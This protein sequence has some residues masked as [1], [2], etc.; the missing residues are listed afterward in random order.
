MPEISFT[1]ILDMPRAFQLKLREYRNNPEIQEYFF[2]HNI[3]LE[4]HEKWLDSL[5][6][7]ENKKTFIFMCDGEPAGCLNISLEDN[8]AGLGIY[9]F[10]LV[11]YVGTGISV[12]AMAY[13]I[14]YL[15]D[16]VE[17]INIQVFEDNK[18]AFRF[19]RVFGFDPYGNDNVNGR[20]VILMVLTGTKWNSIR[21]N[22]YDIIDG[23]DFTFKKVLR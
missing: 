3:S 1:N 8:I 12:S 13:M 2:T 19:N 4:A 5:K 21:G 9:L 16:T 10:S 6:T 11:K 18:R 14:D 7:A 22:I 15:F 20:S 17:T 23:N